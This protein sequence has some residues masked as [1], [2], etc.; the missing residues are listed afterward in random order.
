MSRKN[1]KEM[2][3]VRA[4][5]FEGQFKLTFFTGAWEKYRHRIQENAILAFSGKIEN[6]ETFGSSM[7]V[8]E[9]LAPEELAAK[10]VREI[11]IQLDPVFTDEKEL[12]PLR[13]YLCE[14]T[15]A[16]SV[17]FHLDVIEEQFTV[18]ASPQISITADEGMIADLRTQPCVLSVW[19]E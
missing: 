9:V 16:C 14:T 8:E 11:H 5:D 4:E 18:K 2:G 15:G 17:F 12:E 7:H 13:D 19:T 3:I 6:S 1:G 10:S